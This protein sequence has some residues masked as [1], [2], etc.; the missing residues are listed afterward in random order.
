MF[1]DLQESLPYRLLIYELYQ[2]KKYFFFAHAKNK[3]ADQLCSNCTADAVTAQ[4][5][6]SFVFDI[7]ITVFFLFRQFQPSS[8]LLWLYSLVCV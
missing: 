1:Y 7:K 2:E 6:S 8:H 3:A 5:T 4:L